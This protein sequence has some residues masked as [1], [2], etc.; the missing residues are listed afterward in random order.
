MRSWNV[1]IRILWEV[2]IL[3]S[4]SLMHC[5]GNIFMLQVYFNEIKLFKGFNKVFKQK[6]ECIFMVKSF[7]I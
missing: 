5:V 2:A 1:D 3:V 4:N 6:R 7:F